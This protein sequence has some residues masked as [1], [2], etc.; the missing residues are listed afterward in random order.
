MLI[1]CVQS[2]TIGNEAES[3]RHRTMNLSRAVPACALSC[4][5]TFTPS[6]AT[7]S[8]GSPEDPPPVV[9]DSADDRRLI[10]LH[11]QK[12]PKDPTIRSA[13]DH[14]DAVSGAAVLLPPGV[15]LRSGDTVVV[16][17]R[18]GLVIHRGISATCTATSSVTN[19]YKSNNAVRAEHTYGLGSGCRDKT[20]PVG[21]LDS[22][23]PPLWHQRDFEQ[24]TVAPNQTMYWGTMRS[25]VNSTPKTWHA[26]NAVGSSSISL[27]ADKSLAC[28]PG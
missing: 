9:R 26:E 8:T 3:E 5:L 25:C 23:A 21:L 10:D 28:N 1:T 27:S 11:D 18:D 4:T 13:A 6:A 20:A 14:G 12:I 7:A 24:V 2:S 15:N 16:R 19:P 17:Y 22:W